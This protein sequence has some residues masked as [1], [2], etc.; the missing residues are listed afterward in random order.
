MISLAVLSEADAPFGE[1][2]IVGDQ[3][4]DVSASRDR[5]RTRADEVGRGEMEETQRMR[6]QPLCERDETA[7][8]LGGL[9]DGHRKDCVARLLAEVTRWL[10]GQMPQ[11]RDV[12]P[13]I[14]HIRRPSQN[15]SNPR[16]SFT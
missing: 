16:N 12:M 5:S 7:Q 10:V 4:E 6:L 3:A 9:R 13:P 1:L 15:F 11:I 2:L 14:S 8:F